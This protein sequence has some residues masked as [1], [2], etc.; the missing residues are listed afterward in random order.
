M[1]I[2]VKQLKQLIREA[3]EEA[4]NE[5]EM[6][7][8][9]VEEC[10]YGMS[11]EKEDGGPLRR[12]RG[13]MEQE[14]KFLEEY[15]AEAKKAKKAKEDKKPAKKL[16]AFIVKAQEKAAAKKKAATEAAK[17]KPVAKK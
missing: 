16:P 11:A 4:Y 8:E 10:G 6:E 5:G 15:L 14:E 13:D 7:E 2:T 17:K 9:T 1:Q 12:G 3:V